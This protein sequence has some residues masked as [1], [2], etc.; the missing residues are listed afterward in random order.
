MWSKFDG[1]E[2]F[3]IPRPVVEVGAFWWNWSVPF[4]RGAVNGIVT[5]ENF[6]RAAG[7]YAGTLGHEGFEEWWRLVELGVIDL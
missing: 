5:E 3:A 4:W 6:N 7:A 1:I 2:K